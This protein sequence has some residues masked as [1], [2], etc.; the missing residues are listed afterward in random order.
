VSFRSGVG[1]LRRTDMMEVG[2][3]GDPAPGGGV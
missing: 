3:P 1:I 2:A